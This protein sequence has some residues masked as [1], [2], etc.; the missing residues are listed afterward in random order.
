MSAVDLKSLISSTKESGAKVA[1]LRDS[2]TLAVQITGY[3]EADGQLLAVGTDITTQK[4]V[5]VALIS[6]LKPNGEK[7]NRDM[8]D[9]KA[10]S[11][12]GSVVLF[13]NCFQ[14][15]KT[16]VYTSYYAQTP[17]NVELKEGQDKSVAVLVGPARTII[18]DSGRVA[19][20]LYKIEEGQAVTGA[21]KAYTEAAKLFAD[22]KSVYLRVR[23]DAEQD[24]QKYVNN[25]AFE[26]Y[27]VYDKVDI[28]GGVMRNEVNVEASVARL[29]ES[30][31]NKHW[32][33]NYAAIK[34]AI[35]DGFNI[36]MMPVDLVWYGTARKND[37]KEIPEVKRY[38]LGERNGLFA[39]AIEEFR[40]DGG[41]KVRK[42]NSVATNMIVPTMTLT[43]AS[44][45]R[46]M[47][48]GANTL[49]T[50]PTFVQT[51]D[52]PIFIGG[53]LAYQ[54]SKDK[55]FT[56]IMKGDGTFT[57]PRAPEQQAAPVAKAEAVATE[58]PTKT[59]AE[60]VVPDAPEPEAV[61]MTGFD[62]NMGEHNFEDID[63]D[64]ILSGMEE[65]VPAQAAAPKM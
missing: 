36:D 44:G 46:T 28:G 62:E 37:G 21:E 10:V 22:G 47:V 45:T 30:A 4:V 57:L 59:V 31:I 27:P 58:A 60:A 17:H 33:A 42:Y 24:G 56:R 41:D 34:Q 61:E 50:R 65:E 53:E 9:I 40:T 52:L 23:V 54:P 51:H 1:V 18:T 35:G 55:S 43:D 38:A 5:E 14:D 39:S 11:P 48:L 16:S 6:R 13:Q 26:C 64:S 15:G 25:E 49:S 8:S 20:A 63:L 3:K 32:I 2:K 29:K 19:V 12:E 7:A